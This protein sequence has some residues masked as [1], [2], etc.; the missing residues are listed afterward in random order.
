MVQIL[1]RW[2]SFLLSLCCVM[3]L[4]G[5]MSACSLRQDPPR[6]IVIEALQTQIVATQAS[7][8][9]SLGLDP[10]FNVPSVSRV[11]VDHQEVLQLQ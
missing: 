11:R 1:R 10:A 5:V 8:S 7:I 4:A 3:A 9:E 6:S 2:L